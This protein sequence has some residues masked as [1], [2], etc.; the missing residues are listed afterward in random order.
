MCVVKGN[1]NTRTRKEQKGSTENAIC[2]KHSGTGKQEMDT[3][4]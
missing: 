1:T 4:R 3:K 2:K